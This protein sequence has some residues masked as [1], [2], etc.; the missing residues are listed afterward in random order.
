M[1]EIHMSEIH[2]SDWITELKELIDQRKQV[3]DRMYKLYKENEQ[4]LFDEIEKLAHHYFD[5]LSLEEINKKLKPNNFWET[6]THHK[7]H[8]PELH[9]KIKLME[10]IKSEMLMFTSNGYWLEKLFMNKS[11]DRKLRLTIF[12]QT[13]IELVYEFS[14]I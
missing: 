10:K 13:R 6:N 5:H 3:N 1:S 8:F 4:N 7:I 11:P 12:S 9:E 2:K 14:I